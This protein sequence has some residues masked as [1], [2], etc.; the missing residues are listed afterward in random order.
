[1]T[2]QLQVR[3]KEIAKE[4]GGN[5]ALC[6]KSGV[7]ER[8]FANWLAG[9]SEPKIIGIA[10]IA[11]AAGVT[12]DWLVT[13]AKPKQPLGTRIDDTFA[14]VHVPVISK[15]LKESDKPSNERL[16]LQ[17]HLPFSK[18]FLEERLGHQEF[19]QLC[20]FKVHGDSMD[21]TMSSGDYVLVDRA[22]T[23]LEDGIYAFL[24][25]D[26]INIKRI[27]NMLDGVE[28]ISDNQTLYPPYLIKNAHLHQ[29]QVIGRALWVGKS[30]P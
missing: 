29:M 24:F 9:S 18:S 3:L 26:Q 16:V 13:G 5:R 19:D 8:T 20:L 21:S 2:D 7:S 1:M 6:E 12:I 30:I 28:I 11:H 27:I 23:K 22:Q 25:K 17:N 10:A 15:D 14:I 4:C